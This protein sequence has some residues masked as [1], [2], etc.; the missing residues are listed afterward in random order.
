MRRERERESL[1][2]CGAGAKDETS[3]RPVD[4]C[5]IPTIVL[6]RTV[7]LYMLALNATKKDKLVHT[8]MMND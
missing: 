6:P 7:T 3:V 2:K 1:D 4:T 8:V 5:L